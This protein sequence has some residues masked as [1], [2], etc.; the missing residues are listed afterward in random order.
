[1]FVGT[2]QLERLSGDGVPVLVGAP[3]LDDGQ[4]AVH[5]HRHR[6]LGHERVR[7]V[8]FDRVRAA[9]V[10]IEDVVEELARIAVGQLVR[11]VCRRVVA[12][13]RGKDEPEVRPEAGL[14]ATPQVCASVTRCVC[15]T[16]AGCGAAR[17]WPRA[18]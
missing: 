2:K 11:R 4:P 16:F 12:A 6:T 5:V 9:G 14:A 15:N 7:D 1:M 8:H 13:V 3:G 17:R 18:A 10:R